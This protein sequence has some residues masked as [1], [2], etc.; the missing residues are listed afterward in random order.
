[1]QEFRIYRKWNYEKHEYE[2]YLVSTDKKLTLYTEDFEEKIN[3]CQCL[4][5]IKY[6]ES[7]TSLEVHNSIG[8]GYAV[9]SECY[10][11]EWERRMEEKENGYAR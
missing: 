4:K 10:K 8:L 9:C 3:C 6:G 11:K 1:M 7:Y 2:P 5:K